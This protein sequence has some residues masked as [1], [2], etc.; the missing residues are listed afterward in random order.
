MI[1]GKISKTDNNTALENIGSL[2]IFLSGS[3]IIAGKIPKN[4]NIILYLFRKP[5]ANTIPAI[6][7][8]I[9]SSHFMYLEIVK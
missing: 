5:R 4:K 7:S 9:F 8:Q 2:N 6:R 3:M 1:F